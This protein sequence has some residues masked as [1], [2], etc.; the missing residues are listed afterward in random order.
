M[1]KKKKKTTK[2]PLAFL[3]STCRLP[4]ISH[5]CLQQILDEFDSLRRHVEYVGH[6]LGKGCYREHF[7]PVAPGRVCFCT[8]HATVWSEND[9]KCK[10]TVLTMNSYSY[11]MLF[12]QAG[13]K[14]KPLRFIGLAGLGWHNHEVIVL[15]RGIWYRKD[16]VAWVFWAQDITSR[17]QPVGVTGIT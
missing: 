11:F 17:F 4:Y 5:L 7:W 6:C 15:W 2:T 8:C 1:K 9:L 3:I 16:F 13:C 14:T 10:N 12:F